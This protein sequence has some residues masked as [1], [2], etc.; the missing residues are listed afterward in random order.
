[1]KVHLAGFNLDAEVIHA[2]IKTSPPRLDI[3]PETLSAAY[4]RI[5]RDPRPVDELRADARKEVERARRSNQ[6]I[7]FKMGHHSIAEH[8][9][10][11]FD[12][13]GVSRL[14]IEAIEHFRL[15][16]YTEKS[17]RYVKLGGEVVIPVEIKEAGKEEEFISLTRHQHELYQSLYERL[18][19][20]F[21]K[22]FK[23]YAPEP[24]N[25]II[26]DNW[27]KED[28]RYVLSLSTQSQL[29]MTVNART[30]EL[31]IRRFAGSKLAELRELGKRLY[32]LASQVAPS[33]LLFTEASPYETLTYEDLAQEVTAFIKKKEKLEKILTTKKE[34]G[35]VRLLKW[36]QKGDDFIL[37]ALIHR[38]LPLSFKACHQLVE[39]MS[40]KEKKELFLASFR[41]LEFYDHLL[42]EFEHVELTYELIVSASAFAQLKRHRL[43][44]LTCQSY[45]PFL[46]VTIP[47]SIKAIGASREFLALIKQAESLYKQLKPSIGEAASYVLTN[48]HR[49]RLLFKANVRELYHISRLREDLSA[50]WDIRQLVT[51]MIKQAKK[52]LPLSFLLAGG[53]D[54]FPANYRRIFKE[55]P[56]SK[57]PELLRFIAR[58]QN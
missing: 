6:T 27:A 38:I 49:R 14:A 23:E 22:K 39:N 13:I 53:K 17:Q 45:D 36:T 52:V 32:D 9:V 33:L 31:M 51:R 5:S 56:K 3:T 25:Q 54:S 40:A 26:L 10:F 4:A 8:A 2:L 19:P 18:R 57:P 42:R 20:Y 11:N 44:T 48:A 15:A 34:K 41:R 21:F 16:S 29:G 50:Q 1:M 24:K 12:I 7:I 35:P 43:A 58:P 47:P 55:E 30:L 46:G 37:A 28:A